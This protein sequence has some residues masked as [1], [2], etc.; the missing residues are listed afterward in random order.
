MVH[1]HGKADMSFLV[2]LIFLMLD[3]SL[4][5]SSCLVGIVGSIAVNVAG[6]SVLLQQFI[7]KQRGLLKTIYDVSNIDYSMMLQSINQV[8]EDLS[9]HNGF[10]GS[11][12]HTS[13]F[14]AALQLATE[15][16]LFENADT[17]SSECINNDSDGV[18]Y[19]VDEEEEIDD[20]TERDDDSV[21]TSH[22]GEDSSSSDENIT[23]RVSSS[24]V[25]EE[26]QEMKEMTEE[27]K[28]E[29]LRMIESITDN[30]ETEAKVRSIDESESSSSSH[31]SI[32][33]SS[34]S[35]LPVTKNEV[36]DLPFLTE[37]TVV[38]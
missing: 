34:S 27:E 18:E 14:F 31:E 1:F 7:G 20:T 28:A 37:M 35:P 22:S 26:E 16:V 3:G 8:S 19:T 11:Q 15:R 36:N 32:S 25:E 21:R 38:Y 2:P 9:N 30:S 24:S 29:R 13:E 12:A 10:I 33:S 6:V 17:D 23:C 5:C 4:M